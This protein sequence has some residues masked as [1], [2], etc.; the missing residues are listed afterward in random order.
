MKK[1]EK[2]RF[3]FQ[4]FFLYRLSFKIL[5][6]KR[7]FHCIC[8]KKGF[9]TYIY[10]S[11]IACLHVVYIISRRFKRS[12]WNFR[13][14]HFSS[15]FLS[16]FIILWKYWRFFYFVYIGHSFYCTSF[17]TENYISGKLMLT[18]LNFHCFIY[19]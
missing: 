3:Y 7:I 13:W 4:F 15:V 6:I 12:N 14:N 18:L 8:L 5:I 16:H 2:F 17:N 19:I 10:I 9:V 1:K 11:T